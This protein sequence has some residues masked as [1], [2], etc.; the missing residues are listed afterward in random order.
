MEFGVPQGSVLG[1]ILFNIYIRSLFEIIREDGFCTSGYADD[2]N[3]YQSYAMHFQLDVITIQLPTLMSK[4]K[5]WMNRHFLKINPDKTE[6]IV[7]L[8]NNLSNVHTIKGTFL[9]SDCIRFSNFV[10]N[11]GF[12]LD[13]FLDMDSH[14]GAIVSFSY[15]LIGNIARICFLIVMLNPCYNLLLAVVWT[16]VTCCCTV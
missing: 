7:F 6:I 2:N 15:K 13:R 4:I 1:P 10:K 14:V 3:A 5:E 9:E 8:P 12:T 11:L 16:T